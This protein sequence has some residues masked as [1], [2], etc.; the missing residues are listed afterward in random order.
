MLLHRNDDRQV[1]VKSKT[2]LLNRSFHTK[3]CH[4][5]PDASFL[6]TIKLN[7]CTSVTEGNDQTKE[8]RMQAQDVYTADFSGLPTVPAIVSQWNCRHKVE[9]ATRKQCTKTCIAHELDNQSENMVSDRNCRLQRGDKAAHLAGEEEQEI[10]LIL[11]EG[12]HTAKYSR[13]L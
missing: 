9:N 1:E 7:R 3:T 8:S 4:S 13:V 6:N 10:P 12:N 2:N 5:R 11:M